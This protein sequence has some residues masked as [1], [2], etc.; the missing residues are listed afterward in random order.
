M[1]TS[2]LSTRIP[3]TGRGD[4]SNSMKRRAVGE[5]HRIGTTSGLPVRCTR[6][7]ICRHRCE[8]VESEM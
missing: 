7:K 1:R 6:S 3:E 5:S 8:V 2:V 4:T